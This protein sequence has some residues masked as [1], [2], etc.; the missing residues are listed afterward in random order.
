MS[1]GFWANVT[2][3]TSFMREMVL[4]LPVALGRVKALAKKPLGL[5]PR[6]RT[7]GLSC[8]LIGLLLSH[9]LG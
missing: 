8:R 6:R 9:T 5:V 7:G 2:G 3:T 1:F 4:Y